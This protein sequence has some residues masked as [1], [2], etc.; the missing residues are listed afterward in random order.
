[1]TRPA[2]TDARRPL[3]IVGG[4]PAGMAAAIEAARAGLRCTLIDESPQLGGQIYRH[5][6]RAFRVRDPRVLG[7]D[8]ERG[9]RLRAE[10]ATAAERVEI[11]AET[12][13]LGIWGGRD[14]LCAGSDGRTL[15]I[16][17]ERLI[18]ATGARDRPVPFPG[19]TLPGVLTAG[20][21]QVLVKTMRV[22]P[23]NRAIVSG[24]GPLLLVVAMQ[25]HLAGVEVVAVLEAGR[26]R[27]TPAAFAK[28]WRE[29]GLLADAWS[30]WRGLRRAG[31]PLLFNH[32]VFEAEG[33]DG[34]SAATWGP[35]DDEWRP[36]RERARRN[37]VDLVVT[38]FGFVPNT[39]LTE[40]AG[41][42]HRFA[43]ELG[44]W[45]PERDALMR[46]SVPGVLAAG[47]SC[48]VA[49]SLV[50]V[51]EGRVAGITAAEEAGV[52][53]PPEAERRRDAPLRRLRAL[54]GVREVL[55]EMSRMRPGLVELATPT[56]IA[57]RCEEVT[58]EQVRAAIAEGA[59]DLQA[60][61]L[62]TRLGMGACQ[63]RNCEP[64]CAALVASA[65]GCEVPAAGRIAARPPVKP[66]TLG[67]LAS[68]PATEAR[69]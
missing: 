39:E 15:D 13:V 32:A 45:V 54:A 9:E 59:R 49:G 64:S 27:V 12:T 6:P 57:C 48:G 56:T 17:A 42:R 14:L 28:V 20:G 4:G 23:G 55:D 38:G 41:C 10:L 61:K 3:V 63:G 8:F 33:K 37:D 25:L 58:V 18:L 46:T 11:L 53:S 7:K 2:G 40:L 22:R 16:S 21:A 26:P 35:V 66:V 19:W 60:I 50:A 36:L 65:T 1:M 67:E 52:L 47:D 43:D 34:V 69:P 30:Y 51:C 29:W 68:P 31:I 5:P 62:F 44:G 24:T